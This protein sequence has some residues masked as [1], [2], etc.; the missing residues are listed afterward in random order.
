MKKMRSKETH[1]NHI[2]IV[3]NAKDEEKEKIKKELRKTIRRMNRFS[4]GKF[5]Y[6]IYL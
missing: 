5:S 6:K 1:K 3:V 2:I 4:E